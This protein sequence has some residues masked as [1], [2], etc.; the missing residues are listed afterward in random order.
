MVRRIAYLS[1]KESPTMT[2]IIPSPLAV[3]A[4]RTLAQSALPDAPVEPEDVRP[5]SRVLAFLRGLFRPASAR[6][7]QRVDAVRVGVADLV[8]DVQGDSQGRVGLCGADVLQR[9]GEPFQ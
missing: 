3:E 8:V 7:E 2:F 4:T 1:T 5:R 6:R 9:V